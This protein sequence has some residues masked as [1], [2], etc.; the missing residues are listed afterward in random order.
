MALLDYAKKKA[1][2]YFEDVINQ[3]NPKTNTETGSPVRGMVM[4]PGALVYAALVQDI[5]VLRQ[6]YLGN[7]ENLDRREMD[8][9]AGNLLQDRPPGTRATT[10]LRLYVAPPK[11]FELRPFPYFSNSQGAR[12]APIQRYRFEPVDFLQDNQGDYYVNVPVSAENFGPRGRTGA[13]TITNFRNLPIEAE[14]V[15]NP[16]PTQGGEPEASNEA[17]FEALQDRQAGPTLNQD[18]GVSN[19]IVDAYP[20][21]RHIDVVGPIDD[22]MM[23]DEVWKDDEHGFNLEQH[24]R[25][26]SNHQEVTLDFDQHM[27]RAVASGQPFDDTMEGQRLQLEN[28]DKRFRYIHKVVSDDEIVVSGEPLEGTTD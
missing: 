16:S 15:T 1:L 26:A 25:P 14:K 23:R 8:R 5:E 20:S 6:L 2:N 19:Y 28:E 22:A 12:Y 7:Y 10:T 13:G 3:A 11:T 18:G 24:G 27:G 17:F 9:L 21:V 4:L